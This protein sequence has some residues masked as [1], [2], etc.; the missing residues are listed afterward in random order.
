MELR[1]IGHFS[2]S[3]MNLLRTRVQ[4]DAMQ[5]LEQTERGGWVTFQHWG[6][7]TTYYKVMKHYVN[8]GTTKSERIFDYIKSACNVFLPY[9]SK[10]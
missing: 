5:T 7:W 4:H 9:F 1:M 10:F 2:E 6:L 8:A 3:D